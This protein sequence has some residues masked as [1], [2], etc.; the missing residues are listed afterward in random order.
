[1]KIEKLR[2]IPKYI[3]E[4]IKKKDRELHPSQ[5]GN[6]RFYSYLAKN[7]AV[8]RIGTVNRYPSTVFTR[9]EPTLKI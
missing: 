1:M 7:N 8:I 9:I 6:T 3:V 4:R 2:P 5:D